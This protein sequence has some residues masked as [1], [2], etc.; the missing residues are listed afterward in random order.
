M[1]DL[2]TLI[3]GTT[4]LNGSFSRQLPGLQLGIDSTSL[5]E[6]KVCPR[7]YLYGIVLGYQPSET[8]VHLVFGL[9]V[10]KGLERYEHHRASGASH[11][12]ALALVVR[13]LLRD[14]WDSK[15]QRAWAST[16]PNKNRGTLLRTVVWYLDR[17]QDDSMET[18][19]LE[20]GK[21]AVELSFRFDSGYKSVA[22]GE[23]FVFCGHIDR[24]AKFNGMTVILDPKTTKSTLG[25]HFF[26]SFTPGNQFSMYALA[27]QVVFNQKISMI[28]VDGIQVL[29]GESRF[30]RG[31]APRPPDVISEWHHEQGFWLAQM[32]SSARFLTWPGNDKSCNQYGG[33]PFRSV[34]EKVPKARHQWLQDNFTQRIW[35]PLQ[36]RGDI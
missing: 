31:I 29:V 13:E 16:D 18:V 24:I 15:R 9:H 7:K 35:D 25:S 30:Q 5:G 11:D 6:Y 4:A 17:F 20:N 10:H 27:G 33:C 1:S 2:L 3:E 23:S 32:E 28:I 12:A 36:S 34:C 26:N 22:T 21:P 8:S 14:T 19:L